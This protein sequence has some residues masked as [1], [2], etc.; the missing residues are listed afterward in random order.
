[1]LTHTLMYL[2]TGQGH[3][4]SAKVATTV[5]AVLTTS[6]DAQSEDYSTHKKSSAA[7]APV[8]VLMEQKWAE[9]N[10]T[11]ISYIL[12]CG[13]SD[14]ISDSSLTGSY[15]NDTIMY[16]TLRAMVSKN[17][18]EDVINIEFINY[19]DTT[20]SI[21]EGQANTWMIISAVVIPLAILTTGVV[22]YFKRRHR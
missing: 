14:Y 19:A 4:D 22:I 17:T 16:T 10:N 2:V 7:N 8:M 9:N 1:M 15:V 21:T 6:K 18:P 20:L 11:L 12:S 3:T 13:T 5:S